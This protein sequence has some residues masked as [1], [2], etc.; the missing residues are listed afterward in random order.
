MIELDLTEF[1]A[2][3]VVGTALVAA[4][5]VG[6]DQLRI[7]RAAKAIRRRTVT[8]RICGA[9]Y[10]GDENRDLQ[11]CPECGSTNRSG[12]DRRLG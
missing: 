11:S 10:L 3:A 2:L 8:C 9:R 4:L 5:S 7:R 12:R 1:F 6:W